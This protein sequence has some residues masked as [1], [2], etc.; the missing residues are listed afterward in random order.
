MP[1]GCSTIVPGLGPQVDQTHDRSYSHTANK[2]KIGAACLSYLIHSLTFD[3]GAIEQFE[4]PAKRA[5]KGTRQKQ[6][7]HGVPTRTPDV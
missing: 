3:C 7:I 1:L 2:K 5:A 4:M 6:A